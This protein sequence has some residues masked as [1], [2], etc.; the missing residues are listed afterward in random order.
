PFLLGIGLRRLS[1]DPQFMPEVFD[2]IA[3]LDVDACRTHARLLIRAD[4]IAQVRKIMHDFQSR[5]T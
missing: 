4:R 1:L 5:P 2:R 3:G